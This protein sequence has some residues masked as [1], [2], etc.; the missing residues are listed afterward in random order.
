M[1]FFLSPA[2]RTMTNFYFFPSDPVSII[3]PINADEKEGKKGNLGLEYLLFE[4]NY[5]DTEPKTGLKHLLLV[6]ISCVI[7]ASELAV[8]LQL[9]LPFNSF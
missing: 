5:T 9:F 1:I 3:D 6:V 4:S 7:S 2:K 8:S